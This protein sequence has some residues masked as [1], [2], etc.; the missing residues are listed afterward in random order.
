MVHLGALAADTQRTLVGRG[1]EDDRLP[2]ARAVALRAVLAA[3]VPVEVHALVGVGPA[4]AE[5]DVLQ[6]YTMKE[7]LETLQGNLKSTT[8]RHQADHER[9]FADVHRRG[10]ALEEL[11]VLEPRRVEAP[12]GVLLHQLL[13][14]AEEG[15]RDAARALEVLLGAQVA[16]ESLEDHAPERPNVGCAG[17][18]PGPLAALDLRR[19]V[20]AVE[21]RVVGAQVA[22]RLVQRAEQLEPRQLPVPRG[23]DEYR[24]GA[25]VAVDQAALAEEVDGLRQLG[26][27]PRGARPNYND[28]SYIV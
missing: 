21:L 5:I 27:A 17:L 10:R 23:R 20:P 24:V 14:I 2:L 9:A 22:L 6:K 12:R 1:L 7:E 8:A 18:Q 13:V 28:S 4:L 19:L 25:D 26:R 11:A 15:G 3:V 16:V